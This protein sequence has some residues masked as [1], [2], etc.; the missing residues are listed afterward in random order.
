MLTEFVSVKMSLRFAVK[1][2]PEFTLS[3]YGVG[4][5]Y[6]QATVIFPTS[7]F[8]VCFVFFGTP[9]SRYQL[10]GNVSLIRESC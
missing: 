7:F 4:T 5:I 3:S 10:Q 6:F 9:G 8:I 1:A 2:G